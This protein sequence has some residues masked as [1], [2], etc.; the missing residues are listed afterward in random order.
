MALNIQKMA[1]NIQ[2]GVRPHPTHP[3]R[4]ATAVESIVF[5]LAKQEGI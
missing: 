1:L 3:L 4:Y 2:S 5:S